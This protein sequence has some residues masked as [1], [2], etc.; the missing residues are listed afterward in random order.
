MGFFRTL[1]R[2]LIPWHGNQHIW[3]TFISAIV[4]GVLFVWMTLP[5]GDMEEA[6]DHLDREVV[7]FIEWDGNPYAAA[8]H[9]GRLEFNLMVEGPF[10]WR[11]PPGGYWTLDSSPWWIRDTFDPAS[12]GKSFQDGRWMLYGRVRDPGI[13]SIEYRVDGTWYPA[14]PVAAPGFIIVLDDRVDPPDRVLWR[15]TTGK[16]IWEQSVP[17]QGG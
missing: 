5:P 14:E 3:I 10:V 13:V 11:W 9:M 6:E 1:R 7:A 8:R 12:V 4:L 2:I 16:I 17:E 15:D